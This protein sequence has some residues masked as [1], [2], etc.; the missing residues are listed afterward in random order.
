VFVTAFWA[1]A[2]ALSV[3]GKQQFRFSLDFSLLASL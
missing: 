1:D 3:H 2:G